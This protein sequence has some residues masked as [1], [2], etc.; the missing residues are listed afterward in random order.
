MR[1][2]R[3]RLPLLALLGLL[4]GCAINPVTGE[5]ELMLVSESQE[6]QL[7]QEADQQIVA[8]YGLVNDPNLTRYLDDLG[9]R[10][11]GV[12]HVAEWEF[13]F[14]LLDDPVIN[15]FALP[16]GYVYV[17]RGILAHLESEA[18]LAGVMGHEVGHVAAR[19][20][21]QR[22]TRQYLYGATFGLVGGL[23]GDRA[24]Q[25]LGLAGI[26]AQ[27]LMLKYG[28]DD[29]RQSDELGVMYATSL[30]YDTTDMARFFHTLGRL[31]DMSGS[32]LPSW[33]STHPDPGERYETVL[34]LT[35]A[36]QSAG[37][38]GDYRREREAFLQRLEGLVFGNDPRQ[39]FVRGG[40]F[41]H[42]ELRLRFP[43]PAQWKVQNSATQVVV[44]PESGET[45]MLFS[46]AEGG[47]AQAAA[48]AFGQREGVTVRRR[49]E[50]AVNGD[51]AVRLWTEVQ[52]E[53]VLGTTSTFVERDGRVYVFHG[54]AALADLPQHEPQLNAI[55]DGFTRLTDPALLNIQPVRLHVVSAARDGTFAQV[56]QGWPIPADAEI[57]VTRLALLNGLQPDDQVA[58]GTQLK[59]LVQAQ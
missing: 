58:A 59:V 57:D 48:D 29:E 43:V 53:R 24:G 5:R 6:R 49:A 41:N 26:P 47:S 33:A 32:R 56:A 34:Q 16:G 52:G 12:S 1:A 45:A 19:H 31:S 51:R 17:T 8:Q 22:V 11:K 25:L 18:G 13:Q 44:A 40:H 3:S 37:A 38:A 23:L 2:T 21:A 4:A 35:Q 54:L 42:P 39:G 10:L 15:A 7:G 30:G 9:Q 46:I 27:L 55:A 14:R 50:L 20:G 28:R 36:E